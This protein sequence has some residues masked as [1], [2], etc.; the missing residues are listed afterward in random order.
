M[1]KYWH[2]I[3]FFRMQ[4]FHFL[5]SILTGTKPTQYNITENFRK[6]IIYVSN[7]TVIS[8]RHKYHACKNT[9]L[10]KTLIELITRASIRA[11]R[12]LIFTYRM[13]YRTR[14]SFMTA[15][16]T[17]IEQNQEQ[18]WIKL[19][20]QCIL[21]IAINEAIRYNTT[22]GVAVCCVFKIVY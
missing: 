11:H 14:I 3:I 18:K 1:K 7:H 16:D 15:N 13:N 12:S 6:K 5:Q 4:N 17:P 19:S 9:H 22:K 20:V 10:R 8:W 2:F 21:S